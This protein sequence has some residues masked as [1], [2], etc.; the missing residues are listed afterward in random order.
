MKIS[1]WQWTK[2]S[3]PASFAIINASAEKTI[4]KNLAGGVYQFELKV[5]DNVGL[6][7]KDTVQVMV[8]TDLLLVTTATGHALMYGLCRRATFLNQEREWV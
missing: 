2:V 3:G 6:S 1:G 4:V 5:T 8:D 7:A